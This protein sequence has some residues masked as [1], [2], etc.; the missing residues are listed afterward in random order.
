M[1]K[2]RLIF[3]DLD[4]TLLECK[5]SWELIHRRFHTMED[6]R[7]SLEQYRL[8][9]ITYGEFMV[10]DILSWLRKKPKIHIEEIEEALSDYKLKSDA[11][12]VIAELKRRGLKVIILTAAIDLLA[13]K[14]G[15]Q[16][17]ADAVLSN[18]LQVDRYG[19]L[20]G[21]GIEAVDPYKKDEAMKRI[22]REQSVPLEETIAVGDSIYDLNM[23]EAA[24]LGLYF[25][26]TE[27]I[28]SQKIRPIHTLHEILAY[29]E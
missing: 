27:D 2:Y 19:Y 21:K 6:A 8:G 26:N 24:G 23:L 10:K 5:S 28:K 25:G 22:S 29:I 11:E 4:G 17:R 20:T 9:E 3:F 18:R 12:E 1:L 13:E 16:L 7:R 15:R 14:V